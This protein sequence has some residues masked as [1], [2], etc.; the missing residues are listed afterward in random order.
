[1]DKLKT[2]NIAPQTKIAA[3]GF[4]L[5]LIVQ[6]MII[7]PIL[8]K[9]GLVSIGHIIIYF[10][11]QLFTMIVSLYALNCTVIGKCN[12]YAWIMGYIV[13]TGGILAVGMVCVMLLMNFSVV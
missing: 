11:V 7:M 4:S 6:L 13:A 8:A 1:M 9:N 12:L 10:L 3:I 2:L 5:V